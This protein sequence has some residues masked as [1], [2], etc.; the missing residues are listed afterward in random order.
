MGL[1][2]PVGWAASMEIWT[3]ISSGALVARERVAVKRMTERAWVGRSDM[4]SL[5][6]G[7]RGHRSRCARRF[8]A[9]GRGRFVARGL[10][11]GRGPPVAACRGKFFLKGSTM[12]GKL[13]AGTVLCGAM[14][15]V[16]CEG[17]GSSSSST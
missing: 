9:V 11:V 6:C 17:S 10:L 15:V 12:F 13:T 1:S 2:G 14:L 4:G 16:G 3:G 7:D 8:V 5:G